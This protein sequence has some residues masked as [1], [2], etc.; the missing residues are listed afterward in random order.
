MA[1]SDSSFTRALAL[2]VVPLAVVL[3]PSGIAVMKYFSAKG[4]EGWT[5]VTAKASWVG[6]LCIVEQKNGNSW[7][8]QGTTVF[9]CPE[10]EAYVKQNEG[11]LTNLRASPRSYVRFTYD[12]AGA[13]QSAQEYLPNISSTAVTAGQD[14]PI[15]V[16][17]ADPKQVFRTFDAAAESRTLWT[18]IAVGLALGVLSHFFMRLILGANERLLARRAKKAETVER[19]RK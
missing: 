5:P 9:E 3:V 13:Q 8:Q 15:I 6:E 2:W 11:L 10:A 18:W 14:F 1:Q 4:A 12:A 17:P 19:Q 7:S 16:N